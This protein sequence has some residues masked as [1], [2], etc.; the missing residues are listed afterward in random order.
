MTVKW[1]IIILSFLTLST[2][3]FAYRDDGEET[4]DPFTYGALR[5]NPGYGYLGLQ[6]Q[7]GTRA[8]FGGPIL[9]TEFDLV[10]SFTDINLAI[11]PFLHYSYSFQKNLKIENN[12]TQEVN[13]TDL[14]Y[15]L[16][17]YINPFFIGFGFGDTT[18]KMSESTGNDITV[19]S[20]QL[21]FTGGL[22]L[23]KLTREWN[24][25]LEGWYKTSFLKKNTNPDLTNNTA[26]ESLELYINFVWSPLF[27][28]L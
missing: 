24:V 18:L 4:G 27:Q 28:L 19:K 5:L 20:T 26:A 3:A 15:G 25:T 23:F 22:R 2:Q 14:I 11:G 16:K 10:F 1:F 7:D 12:V 17:A 13:K 6:N 8:V 21:G 9:A